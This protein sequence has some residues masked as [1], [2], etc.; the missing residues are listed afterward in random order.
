MIE[1]SSGGIRENETTGPGAKTTGVM[2][3]NVSRLI[4]RNEECLISK[5]GNP[6]RVDQTRRHI[7]G[8][9]RKVRRQISLPVA[10]RLR[11]CVSGRKQKSEQKKRHKTKSNSIFHSTKLLPRATK[12]LCAL[13]LATF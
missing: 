2:D 1:S 3:G 10:Y 4:V 13:A 11:A 6:P 8:H 12:Y 9:V 7:I 5:E